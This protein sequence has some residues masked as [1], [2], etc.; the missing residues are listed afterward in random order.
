MNLKYNSIVFLILICF[1][2][3]LSFAS[4]SQSD[5]VNTDNNQSDYLTDDFKSFDDLKDDINN[6]NGT[7]NMESD[8]KCSQSDDEDS[9]NFYFKNLVINGNNHTFDG[10][11]LTGMSFN[12]IDDENLTVWDRF[13]LTINDLTFINFDGSIYFSNANVIFNNVKQHQIKRRAEYP[14]SGRSS[15][16]DPCVHPA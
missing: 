13:N 6:C 2:F 1:L 3:S 10:N 15:S 11:N 12:R 8:Y 14:D 7:F 16:E 4:A 9:S 5:I